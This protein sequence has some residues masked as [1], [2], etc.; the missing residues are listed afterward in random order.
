[1][2]TQTEDEFHWYNLALSYYGLG[3]IEE[4]KECLHHARRVN[5]SYKAVDVLEKE[6]GL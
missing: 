6:L 1:M 3:D 2:E 5:P 4:A